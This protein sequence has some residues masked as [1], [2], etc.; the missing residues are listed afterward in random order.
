MGSEELKLTSDL[1]E[2]EASQETLNH[3]SA[4]SSLG[5]ELHSSALK[6]AKDHIAWI[7]RSK[8][9]DLREGQ[10]SGANVEDLEKA[11]DVLSDQ[12]YSQPTHFLL[13]FIQNAD[14]N[15]YE[16]VRPTISFTSAHGHLRIDCNEIGFAPANVEAI[17]RIGKSTK[18]DRSKGFIGEKGIGFKSV[19]KIADAVWISS[20]AYTFKFDRSAQ[21]GMIAPIWEGFPG[22]VRAD[23][24]QFYLQLSQEKGSQDEK[25]LLKQLRFFDSTLLLF[26]RKLK[27]IEIFVND[28]DWKKRFTNYITR[29]DTIAYGGELITIKKIWSKTKKADDTL[30]YF[31]VRHTVSDMPDEPKRRAMESSEVVIA[32]PFIENKPAFHMQKAYAFLPIRDSGFRVC[33][34]SHSI[35]VHVLIWTC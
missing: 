23:V 22:D 21:L 32:F 33:I 24:S 4:R 6:R 34:L 16:D 3:G 15:Y 17:C 18:K 11:L 5:Q 14:D 13:E 35:H 31:V 7:R 8:G 1:D 10:E 19:F 26:L 28:I 25:D 12:L 2:I 20:K 30:Q 9:L 27:K 29:T